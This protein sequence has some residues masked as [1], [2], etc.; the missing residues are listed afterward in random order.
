MKLK[1]TLLYFILLLSISAQAQK[2]LRPVTVDT[3]ISNYQPA[4]LFSPMFYPERGNDRHSANGEPGSKYWQKRVNYQL[5]ASIDTSSKTFSATERIYYVNNSP[6][7]LQ[8]LWLQL[9]KN[10]YKK[11]ARSNFATNV[12]SRFTQH[13]DVSQM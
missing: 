6:D 2:K 4:D 11:D 1:F 12:S 3:L 7:S 10:T 13:T 8:Y 5:K 9:D